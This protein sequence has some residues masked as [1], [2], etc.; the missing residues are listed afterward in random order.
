M[1]NNLYK[2]AGQRIRRI[3]E[4]NGFTREYVSLKANISP[5]FL[6]EIECGIKG[7]S[8]DT[9]HKLSMVLNVSSEYIL[10]GHNIISIEPEVK[11]ILNLFSTEQ[12]KEIVLVIKKLYYTFNR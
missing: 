7:F 8:A 6:Y 4:Q 1:K 9:L 5:K 12:L 2:E 3:R 10:N 11:E